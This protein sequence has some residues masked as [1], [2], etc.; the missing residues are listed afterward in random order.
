MATS[1]SPAAAPI[2]SIWRTTPSPHL[3][4]TYAQKAWPQ[5]Y[6][7]YLG[8]F[9]S[10]MV[11]SDSERAASLSHIAVFE[12]TAPIDRYSAMPSMN[13]RGR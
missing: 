4:A 7:K 5:R 3:P 13:Q 11:G 6:G 10:L 2:E 1:G 12:S 9:S 8:L